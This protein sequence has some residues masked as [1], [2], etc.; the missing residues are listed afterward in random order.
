MRP[1]AKQFGLPG[2]PS[3]SL[4]IPAR[5]QTGRG[6][7]LPPLAGGRQVAPGIEPDQPQGN[8]VPLRR[9]AEPARGGEIER[10]GIARHLPHDE[11]Q[12]A[13]TQ[14]FFQRKQRV[15]RAFGRDMDQAVAQLRRQAGAIGPPGQPQGLG[16]LHPQPG[17]LVG[18]VGHR[19]GRLGGHGI[20]RQG[21]GK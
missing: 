9:Q 20:K 1:G 7:R 19:I 14:P 18:R 16:I 5:R 17:A 13:A 4:G 2:C 21:Q 3:G 6:A 12:I 11:G 8:A 10:A 15:L